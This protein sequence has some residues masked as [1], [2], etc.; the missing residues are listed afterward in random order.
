MRR[1]LQQEGFSVANGKVEH[2]H[3]NKLQKINK[4]YGIEYVTSKFKEVPK[5]R[6]ML[7]LPSNLKI[8]QIGENEYVYAGE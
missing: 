2:I 1:A 6:P 3:H 7:I 4:K 8:R 5:N